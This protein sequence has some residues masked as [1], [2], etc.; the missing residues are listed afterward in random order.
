MGDYNENMDDDEFLSYPYEYEQE[1]VD[2]LMK[3]DKSKTQI[4]A[5]MDSAEKGIMENIYDED[6]DFDTK[7]K[8][9]N[10]LNNLYK[11]K[12]DVYASMDSNLRYMQDQYV[13]SKQSNK[14]TE[15]NLEVVENEL[16]QIK[17]KNDSI[18]QDKTNKVRQLQINSFYQQK[19]N[20][21]I[22]VLKTISI[23]SIIVIIV[24]LMKRKGFVPDTIYGIILGVILLIGIFAVSYQLFDI[25]IRDKSKFEEYDHSIYASSNPS[26]SSSDSF[27]EFSESDS[28]SDSDSECTSSS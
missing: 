17:S 23:I 6:A 2:N 8:N 27:I 9:I 11:G 26:S 13:N 20:A 19:Y 25:F 16:K 7:Q 24:S 1:D 4:L 10:D 3:F 22:G 28:D 5:G 15:S 12:F 18:A 21:Q 14:L